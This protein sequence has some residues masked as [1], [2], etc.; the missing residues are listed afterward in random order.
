MPATQPLLKKLQQR[1]AL[2]GPISIATYMEICL[3]DPE[4][5][6]YMQATPFGTAGDFIT[7]PEV[8][9]LFGEIIGAWILQQWLDDGSPQQVCVAEIG[10]GRGTLMKDMLRVFKLRPDFMAASNIHLVETSPKLQQVQKNRLQTARIKWCQ[11]ID[12]LPQQPLYLVANELF[13]ALPIEQYIK[14]GSQW[15]ERAVGLNAEGELCFGLGT[16]TLPSQQLPSHLQS[17]VDGEVLEVSPQS[18]AI[19]AKIASR[20]HQ[21]GGAALL[22]DYGYTKTACGDTFQAL[23]QHQY[24]SPLEAPGEADLTAH[25]NFESL[26]NSGTAQSVHCHGPITQANFLL[27]LGLLQRAGQLGAGKTIAEQTTIRQAVERLA[28]DNE[29]GDLFKVLAFTQS[30]KP[31]LPFPE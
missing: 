2:E 19:A 25:V 5:G 8:S 7:A 29:M 20:I 12:E 16:K 22:I 13:D 27:N 23:K 21:S 9:Q 17:A 14:Q 26:R 11:H 31:P 30:N 10:P 24:V 4:H 6:Y 3:S 28:A 18:Q 15:L 1:I